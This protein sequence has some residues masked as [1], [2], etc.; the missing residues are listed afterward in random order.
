MLHYRGNYAA[1]KK[2]TAILTACHGVGVHH[3]Y[4]CSTPT[5]GLPATF[6][7][8]L[9]YITVV[10]VLHAWFLSA[11]LAESP[12]SGDLRYHKTC[13]ST[14]SGLPYKTKTHLV[15]IYFQALQSID[16]AQ[17]IDI[18]LKYSILAVVISREKKYRHTYKKNIHPPSTS[19][20]LS[21]CTKS[22]REYILGELWTTTVVHQR[23]SPTRPQAY[24]FT[25]L[26]ILQVQ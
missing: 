6:F 3:C 4:Y 15:L 11:C 9:Q 21:L 5:L 7:F 16:I 24:I 23:W 2:L 10:V 14:L 18:F 20:F 13:V 1:K 8:V 19:A 22:T 25:S 17:I 26:Q 12:P